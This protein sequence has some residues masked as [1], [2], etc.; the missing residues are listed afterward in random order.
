MKLT[1]RQID[2]F[3]K[4]PDRAARVILVYGPDDGLVRERAK[5]I[6][7]TIVA[8]LNDPFNAVTLSGEI[9]ASDPAR[10]MDEAMAQS[11]MGGARLIRIEG[12]GDKLT[13]L[14][15]DYLKVPSDSNLVV[16]EG[17]ELGPALPCARRLKRRRT[18]PPSPATWKGSRRYRASRGR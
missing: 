11:L 18:P 16:I 12:G 15:R 13:V 10:L 6:G 9:L 17:G 7:R 8:D 14:I 3:L 2:S 5:T 4:S 1:S